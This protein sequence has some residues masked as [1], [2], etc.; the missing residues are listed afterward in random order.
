MGKPNLTT[1]QKDSIAHFLLV[2]SSNGIPSKGMISEATTKWNVTRKTIL[3]WW[4]RAKTK[5]KDGDMIHLPSARLG[6]INATR[7]FINKAKV[8]SLPK[9]NQ[10]SMDKLAKKLD[11][12][13][14]TIQRWVKSGQL[15]R[16]SSPL[17]P[18]LT[19]ANKIK[20]L[21]FSL[22]STYVDMNLNVIKFKDMSQQ[23]HIDEKWFYITKTTESY[24]ILPEEEESYRACQSK[25]F[26]TKVMFMCAVS[27]P[28]FGE[29]GELLFDGKI[30]IFPFLEEQAAVR[31]SKNREAGTLVTMPT[32][33]INK[34]VIKDCLINKIIPAINFKWPENASKDICIQQD[35]AKPHI[36]DLDPNFRVVAD[37]DG[38]NIHLVFQPPNSPDLNINDLGFFRSLQSLQH[39]TAA[40]TV[41]ELV[42]AVEA[43]FELHVPNKLNF[44]FL[45][46][47]TVMV[48][49]MKCRG[50]NNFSI[51]HMRKRVL[52]R[53]GILPRDIIVDEMLVKE[54]LDYLAEEGQ[55]ASLDYLCEDM[56]QLASVDISVADA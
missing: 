47:Q 39:E 4:K 2:N 38:F 20:R 5:I 15:K 3:V 31:R 37:S 27:R 35:N 24:Y 56:R 55:G 51:P 17:H 25:I 16:H 50:H 18:K 54:C 22:S 41:V 36:S 13:Y 42:G 48:E 11:V 29:E 44:N 14:G 33:S 19:D 9:K 53:Q 8:M 1:D 26:I 12:G 32:N 40:S 52:E 7:V 21:I 46:L 34:Q 30:G 23:V 45:T 10:A 49:I 6:N 28:L 43:A